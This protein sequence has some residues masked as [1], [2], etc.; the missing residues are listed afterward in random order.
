[1]LSDTIIR[2]ESEKHTCQTNKHIAEFC[3]WFLDLSDGRV[4]YT[5][6]YSLGNT[7]LNTND[8][9]N[10]CPLLSTYYMLVTS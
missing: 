3:Q 9:D 8:V 4:L 10:R 1:M 6:G 7:A 5:L 2:E